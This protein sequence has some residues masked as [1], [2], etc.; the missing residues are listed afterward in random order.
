LVRAEK[1]RLFAGTKGKRRARAYTFEIH[2]EGIRRMFDANW[3][4]FQLG[5]DVGKRT[6]VGSGK[7]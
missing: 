4:R 7:K 1:T 3:E 5:V 6:C 2:L